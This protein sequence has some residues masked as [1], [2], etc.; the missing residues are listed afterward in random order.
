MSAR[1]VSDFYVNCYRYFLFT[2]QACDAV[3]VCV[4]VCLCVCVCLEV[5]VHTLVFLNVVWVRRRRERCMTVGD[6]GYCVPDDRCVCA[7][8][9]ACVLTRT[10]MCAQEC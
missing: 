5:R 3:R 6:D 8:V 1:D 4:R 9:C 7:C 10:C 2:A